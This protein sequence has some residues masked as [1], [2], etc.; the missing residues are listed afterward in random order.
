MPTN[1]FTQYKAQRERLTDIFRAQI[2]DVTT[3]S[4]II[5]LTSTKDKLDAFV[6][7]LKKKLF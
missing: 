4:Y 3:K 5:Q 7:T 2:V 6:N 1:T